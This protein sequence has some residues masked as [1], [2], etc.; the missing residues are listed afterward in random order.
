MCACPSNPDATRFRVPMVWGQQSLPCPGCRASHP[1]LTCLPSSLL[2]PSLSCFLL[3]LTLP[4]LP[5]HLGWGSRSGSG[6]E[7]VSPS[8]WQG[9][10]C[11]AGR[12]GHPFLLCPVVPHS[13]PGPGCRHS[14]V[15]VPGVFSVSLSSRV[16]GCGEPTQPPCTPGLS[17]EAGWRKS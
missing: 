7:P 6:C 8:P 17:A 16:G 1:S 2:L 13:S 4:I 3:T 15:F 5:G 12:R 9:C 14:W 11:G 10:G